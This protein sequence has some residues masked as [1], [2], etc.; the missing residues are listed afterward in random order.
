MEGQLTMMKIITYKLA[1]YSTIY[2]IETQQEEKQLH[3][4]NVMMPYSEANYIIAQKEAYE[5]T[6][7]TPEITEK[8][9]IEMGISYVDENVVEEP[10]QLDR[11]EAQIAY[12]AMM[13]D[14]LLED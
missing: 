8:Q 11:I 9:A 4:N 12:T 3:L 5:D 7:E 1:S 10:T 2:N 14:T 13:T 6:L